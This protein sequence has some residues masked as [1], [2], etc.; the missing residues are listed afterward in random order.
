MIEEG[1]KQ[2]TPTSDSL[3]ITPGTLKFPKLR[4]EGNVLIQTKDAITADLQQP[5]TVRL[6]LTELFPGK[7]NQD[8]REDI[9]FLQFRIKNQNPSSDVSITSEKERNKLSARF[10]IY[11]NH[12]ETFTYAVPLRKGQKDIAL[13]LGTGDYQLSDL[14]IF[15]GSWASFNAENT[16]YQ[17]EISNKSTNFQRR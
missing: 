2:E 12:N 3:K 11:Y 4:K 9:L 6:H 10:H 5:E 1:G 7:K 17:S 14:K 16:L 13:T 8:H 15:L